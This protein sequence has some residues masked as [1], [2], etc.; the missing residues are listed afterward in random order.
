MGIACTE[1]EGRLLAKLGPA[2]RM[3]VLCGMVFWGAIANGAAVPTP[4]PVE[5]SD[6]GVGGGSVF[7]SLTDARTRSQQIL[8]ELLPSSHQPGT[9]QF[10]IHQYKSS[11]GGPYLKRVGIEAFEI[12]DSGAARV[13][14]YMGYML[15][16]MF[17]VFGVFQNARNGKGGLEQLST[18]V[19]KCLAG[20]VLVSK[21]AMALVYA[22]LMTI[23]STATSVI[24]YQSGQPTQSR[25]DQM[26]EKLRDQV[27]ANGMN[28]V[29]VRAAKLDGINDAYMSTVGA[30]TNAESVEDLQKI[31]I[32]FNEFVDWFNANG[33]A[34]IPLGKIDAETLNA[35]ESSSEPLRTAI[36]EALDRILSVPP[37][38]LTED[39]PFAIGNRLKLIDDAH[40]PSINQLASTPDKQPQLNAR[41]LAYRDAIRN[42]SQLWVRD[43]LVKP[44]IAPNSSV[45]D[46]KAAI[47]KLW[48]K[49]SA[50][51]TAAT[52]AA[53][54]LNPFTAFKEWF[55]TY[56]R[57]GIAWA[58]GTFLELIFG[59]VVEINLMVLVLV[60]PLWLWDKTAKAFTGAVNNVVMAVFYLPVFQFGVLLLDLMIA[61]FKS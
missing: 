31:G 47:S 13:L 55:M 8:Q 61:Q 15:C 53:S 51:F 58:F 37:H 41:I 6:A 33:K 19:I 22:M 56:L 48:D 57:K 44:A 45:E 46:A 14:I 36:R 27:G 20:G 28:S 24:N 21:S 25:I 54:A 17:A 23:Q 49:V 60:Y 38:V 34:S 7:A 35:S 52:N 4:P 50:G 40:I 3:L 5:A 12:L 43:V 10:F 9:F 2:F 39:N 29:A 11:N 1:I 42:E 26:I 18:I 32:R 59:L 16:M 30:L